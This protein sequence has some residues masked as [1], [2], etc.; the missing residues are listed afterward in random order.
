MHLPDSELFNYKSVYMRLKRIFILFFIAFIVVANIGHAQSDMWSYPTSLSLVEDPTLVTDTE[1]RDGS[2]EKPYTISTAQE[3]AYFAY[4]VNNK[5]SGDAYKGKYVV[6]TADIVLNENLIDANGNVDAKAKEWVPIGEYGTLYNDS[7]E[8]V[9]DG[10]GH[11]IS[12]VYIN[13]NKAYNGLFGDLKHGS[14]KNLHVKD[15]YIMNGSKCTGGVVAHVH[16]SNST[17]GGETEQ[18][19][20]NCSFIG[21]IEGKT[22]TNYTGGIVGHEESSEKFVIRNCTTE[23]FLSDA[24][25]SYVGG[26][27]AYTD[28]TQVSGCVNRM[29]ISG[30]NQGRL[31]GVAAVT[32]AVDNCMNYGDIVSGTAKYIG[33]VVAE[34]KGDALQCVNNGNI[35]V[36]GSKTA[37]VGGVVGLSTANITFCGNFGTI[38]TMDATPSDEL[39]VGGIVGQTGYRVWQCYNHGDIT[40]SSSNVKCAGLVG[41]Y[42]GTLDYGNVRNGFN[43][44]KISGGYA[45][46]AKAKSYG[47]MAGSNVVWLEGSAGQGVPGTDETTMR[48]KEY[49]TDNTIADNVFDM[50]ENATGVLWGSDVNNNGYPIPN[51]LGGVNTY[52]YMQGEYGTEQNP[53]LIENLADINEMRRCVVGG[54][55]FEGKFF[56]QISDID[57]SSEDNFVPIGV[58]FDVRDYAGI[59]VDISESYPFAGNYNGNGCRIEGISVVQGTKCGSAFFAENRGVIKKLDFEGFTIVDNS[60]EPADVAVVAVTN[61]GTISDIIVNDV[62]L[63]GTAVVAGVAG[64]NSGAIENVTVC[65]VVLEGKHTGGVAG[66]NGGSI[67]NASVYN[68]CLEGLYAGGVSGISN[69]K[70]EKTSVFNTDIEGMY[71]GGIVGVSQDAIINHS[72]SVAVLDTRSYEPEQGKKPC[73]GGIAGFA[74][75]ISVRDC[76][77][78]CDTAYYLYDSNKQPVIGGLVGSNEEIATIEIK[79]SVAPWGDVFP[80][81][82]HFGFLVGDANVKSIYAVSDLITYADMYLLNSAFIWRGVA[83]HLHYDYSKNLSFLYKKEYELERTDVE[84]DVKYFNSENLVQGYYMVL[85]KYCPTTYA[86][87]TVGAE[88]MAT[89]LDMSAVK[90]MDNTLFEPAAPVVV[91]EFYNLPNIVSPDGVVRNLVLVDGKDFELGGKSIKAGCVSFNRND[92]CGLSAICLPFDLDVNLLPDGSRAEIVSNVANGFVNAEVATGIIAAGTPFLLHCENKDF[93]LSVTTEGVCNVSTTLTDGLLTG[94][95]KQKILSEGDYY[96]DGD[97]RCFVRAEKDTV[98]NAFTAYIPQNKVGETVETLPVIYRSTG[99]YYRLSVNDCYLTAKEEGLSFSDD[100]ESAS[101]IFYYDTDLGLLSYYNSCYIDND[102]YTAVGETPVVSFFNIAANDTDKYNLCIEGTF[103]GI[104]N[105]GALCRYENVSDSENAEN[106]EWSVEEVECLPVSITALGYAT[107]YAGVAL[108]VP[109][110]VSAHTIVVD[111]DE[112]LLSKPLDV[113]PAGCGVVLVV[114]EE[115]DETTVYEFPV[116]TDDEVVENNALRG[117]VASTF[118]EP[119]VDTAYYTLANVDDV[120][121][122]Y[123]A[124][125]VDGKFYNNGHAVYLTH[126]NTDENAPFVIKFHSSTNI[127]DVKSENGKVRAVY[128][129]QGRRVNTPQIGVYIVN[130]KQMLIK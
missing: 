98:I 47:E 23:G 125:I 33:G 81:D 82:I 19:V 75:D 123:M 76:Y 70:I 49:F 118:V 126:E 43:T 44:G 113:I 15:S 104:D 93:L 84:W 59:I 26:I 32:Y 107:L 112:A 89:Y 124:E 53:Y 42:Q 69:G 122:F 51:I 97:A 111:G 17:H 85:P 121:V 54:E 57:F 105:E 91:D 8:G 115:L 16:G 128:D 24:N 71:I 117:T 66:T 60:Q 50:M 92:A 7:F 95:Y 41:D 96:L 21:I 62:N 109:E 4:Y 22:S 28:G 45:V 18:V 11:T 52:F 40:A 39:L 63:K 119:D 2:K 27:S 13:S 73:M 86:V 46:A 14:I 120:P 67:E 101:T 1:L 72:T 55:S 106:M 10:Q 110:N 79:S 129:L 77:A 127:D 78:I 102:G 87:N 35:N 31:G 48:S 64:D 38:N 80:Q 99:Y 58:R 6:L 88:P 30:C 61:K 83:S 3:L 114:E 36:T 20:E 94:T 90:P 103:W 29:H 34:A 108:E 37:Q 74:Y 12:G 9:F 56:S 116:V 100:V 25:A 5:F 130:G 68:A 65:N